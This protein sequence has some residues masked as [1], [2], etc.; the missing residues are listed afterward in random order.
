MSDRVFHFT[1]RA[2]LEPQANLDAFIALCRKSAIFDAQTNFDDNTWVVGRQKGQNK[3]VR[4]VFSTMEAAKIEK[5]EPPLPHPFR[6]FAK[7]TLIYLHGTRP[8]V[9]P[10]PRMSALRYLEAALRDF[11]KGSRPTAINSEVLD[12]AVELARSNVTASVAYRVAGQLEIIAKFMNSKHFIELRQ[13]WIHGMKK[14]RESGSRISKEA[15]DS[16]LKK[17]PSE[18]TLRAIGSIFYEASATQDV[19]V[20]SFM[21]L[22]LCAPERINEALRLRRNC[23]VEGD[24]RF[25][26]KLGLRWPGSK[27]FNNTTKWLPTQMA[28]IAREAISNLLSVTSNGHELACWYTENPKSMYYS[29]DVKHLRRRDLLSVSELGLL[30]WGN[31]HGRCS[32]NAWAKGRG[33]SAVPLGE[34]SIGYRRID[35]E[36]AVLA[37][38]PETFPY[39]PGDGDLLCKDAIGVVRVNEMHSSRATY[40]CMFECID[41]TVIHNRLGAEGKASI[42]DRLNYTQDDGTRIELNSHS[43]RHY[44][45]MLAQ[46]GGLSSAEIAIFSGRKDIKQNRA[47]DHMTSE[48][49]Q[50][51]ISRA[52]ASGFNASLVPTSSRSLISRE[53][54]M[55]VGLV[56]AHTTEYGWCTHNFAA[57]PCQMFRDCINCQEQECIKGDA[58]KESNLTRLKEET[59]HLLALARQALTNE[60]YGADTWVKHQ[61]MTLQRIEALLKI[62]EDPAVPIGARIRLDNVTN[63]PLITNQTPSLPLTTRRSRKALK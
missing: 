12:R 44:L 48:E 46:M 3:V 52:I 26:G 22:L 31:A 62:M 32:A 18:A 50:A 4:L 13:T 49:A 51:P 39:V 58:H 8:V 20:A 41:Y 21:A 45:N 16:R 9:N 23:I 19:L 25:A 15:L 14:P 42:F 28:P 36:R 59:E 38:L 1:P 11:N 57:E 40:T 7:A 5:A 60:E 10:S 47:Y 63:A 24:G 54:F 33:L 27:G 43:L 6:D 56:T 34:R 37:M 30:L 29:E 2:E 61:S 55:S 53:S 17:L 35:V